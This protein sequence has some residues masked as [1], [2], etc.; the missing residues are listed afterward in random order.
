LSFGRD[1]LDCA[2][3]ET[4]TNVTHAASRTVFMHYSLNA[5]LADDPQLLKNRDFTHHPVPGAGFGLIEK[6]PSGG[7]WGALTTDDPVRETT[8]YVYLCRLR[9]NTVKI[10]RAVS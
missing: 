8:I 1:W 3:T 5:N 7:A 9:W 4:V 2:E 6:R 10:D